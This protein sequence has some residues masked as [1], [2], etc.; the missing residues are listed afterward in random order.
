VEIEM[1]THNPGF[2]ATSKTAATS[3]G[4]AAPLAMFAGMGLLFLGEMP[5][6]GATILM[7]ASLSF[8]C[9]LAAWSAVAEA[10]DGEL[11]PRR[12]SVL[13]YAGPAL[14]ATMLWLAISLAGSLGG[15]GLRAF[16][17]SLAAFAALIALEAVVA[18][19]AMF[20]ARG[21]GRAEPSTACAVL[22]SGKY[23]G[24]AGSLH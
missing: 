7:T 21:L 9:V 5:T 22:V 12:V 18:S 3:G 14:L 20:V 2:A 11:A 24:I 1:I 19:L 15:A 4:G 13:R 8:L 10:V 17:L 23:A 6:L 16:L